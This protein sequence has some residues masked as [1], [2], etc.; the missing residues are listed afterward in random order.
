MEMISRGNSK[1]FNKNPEIV[2][3]T[4]NKEDKYSHIV[5][6]DVLICLLSPYLRHTTQT[7][8]L[9]EGNNPHLCYN[10]STTKKPTDIVINQITPVAR[11]AATTFG[12]VRIQ[13]NIDIYNTRISCLVAVIFLLMGDI[14]A[15]FQFAC[16][17]A[18][19]TGEFGFIANDNY[20]LATAMVLGST[21]SASSW[22][23]FQRAIETLLEVYAKQPDIVSKQ[24]KYLDVIG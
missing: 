20:N 2:T 3:K 16:I 14:K 18:D 8:V 6:L 15:C 13:L 21:T 1:S 19:L 17:H 24:E 7:M 4:M 12:R 10:A 23:P 9:K 22:E 11:E 5:P